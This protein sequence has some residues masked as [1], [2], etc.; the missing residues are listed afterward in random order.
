MK[1]IKPISDTREFTGGELNNGIKYIIVKDD[2]L[3]KSHV[4]VCVNAGSYDAPKGY[5]GLPHFLEHML[6]MG[7][8]KYPDIDYYFNTLNENGGYSNAYTDDCDTVYFFD[9]YN[10][11]LEK[12]LDIFSR[13]F[14]DP[15]FDKTSVKKEINAIDNEHKMHI[16]D[17]MW[18]KIQF[19]LNLTKKESPTN[20]FGTGT[21]YYLD[22]PDILTVL[23]EFHNK[24]YVANNISICIASSFNS[25]QILKILNTYF[26]DIPKGTVNDVI[27]TIP[28]NLFTK[29]NAAY[30][31]Q[32]YSDTNELTY[33]WE[34]PKYKKLM[35]TKEFDII[36]K[37]ICNNYSE[38]GLKYLLVNEGY[39]IDI[40]LE[41]RKEGILL[42]H[43]KLTK[44]GMDNIDIVEGIVFKYLDVILKY[45]NYDKYAKYTQNIY[46]KNFD[47]MDKLDATQLCNFLAGNIKYYGIENAYSGSIN[48][49]EIKKATEYTEMYKK[50][51]LNNFIKIVHN[52][53]E[54]ST[55]KLIPAYNGK[56][57]EID[58]SDIKINN[59][60]KIDIDKIFD[61]ENEYLD[62]N[63]I[64][65]PNLDSKPIEIKNNLWYSGNSGFQEKSVYIQLQFY[66]NEFFKSPKK[67]ILTM[68]SCEIFNFIKNTKLFKLLE[69]PYE[70]SI[71]PSIDFSSI[72]ILIKSF[73]DIDKIKIILDNLYK[74][75]NDKKAIDIISDKYIVNLINTYIEKYNNIKYVNSN[76]YS[77]YMYKCLTTKHEY[78]YEIMLQQLKELDIKTIRE[79]YINLL[80]G[81]IINTFVF[82]NI[83][84]EEVIK[85]KIFDDYNR[86][87]PINLPKSLKLCDSHYI[88]HPHSKE[89]TNSITY[90]YL[91]PNTN[92]KYIDINKNKLLSLIAVE[93]IS[94]EF[95]NVL[96]TKYQLGYLVRMSL[97]QHKNHYYISQTI[98][99]SKPVKLLKTYLKAFNNKLMLKIIDKV[100]FNKYIDIIRK[101]INDPPKS[102]TEQFV[103]YL[104][105]I[106]IQE[107][108][109]D[110]TKILSKALDNITKEDLINF[111]KL[112]INKSNRYQI[113]VYHP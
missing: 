67:Y 14:I 33:I 110:R 92:I 81:S 23:R 7:S 45:D 56:Y 98:Q 57:M 100:D 44:Y 32:S 15:L 21:S 95:F 61:T 109:F 105:E 35:T 113:I 93:M 4:S 85:L 62:L 91:V 79:Y 70:I 75:I 6:F 50:I 10:E 25:D 71:T 112:Y 86:E 82:G 76:K 51:N 74:I 49:S 19:M 54:L 42:L 41:I 18:I 29:T 11:S 60:I 39:L 96:R 58:K 103:K 101:Q 87:A 90:Y 24:Y 107:Y 17:D 99:S 5:D 97:V 88:E 16:T 27:D 102:L 68:L 46:L 8:K 84:S 13:F 12:I 9:I 106:I 89:I 36:Y 69:L 94:Q 48:I 1:I 65:I 53:K 59:S 78:K 38:H 43:L 3:M 77:M 47:Y 64:L 2:K 63:P 20:I 30:Q 52:N 111:V 22:K 26:I 28:D 55:S 34:I 108:Q 104:N 37:I 66:N 83:K 31:L 40:H 80:N 73:N 72:N